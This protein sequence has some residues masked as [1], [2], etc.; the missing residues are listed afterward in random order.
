MLIHIRS[1]LLS[2]LHLEREDQLLTIRSVQVRYC[3]YCAHRR[4]NETRLAT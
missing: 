4:V 3:Q 1:P 2:R